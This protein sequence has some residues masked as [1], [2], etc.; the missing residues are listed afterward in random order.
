M[1]P[2]NSEYKWKAQWITAKEKADT[3]N[4]WTAFRKEIE[5]KGLPETPVMA[6][7][8]VDSKYWLWINGRQVVYEGQLK[9]GPTPVDTYYDVVDISEYLQEGKNTI[10]ALVWFFG[11]DGFSHNNSG[12]SGLVFDIQSDNLEIISDST[13][14]AWTHPSFET[15]G[16]PHP[17]YR[18][19][20]SNIAFNALK[21]DLSF[22]QIKFNDTQL[23]YAKALGTPPIAP[24]NRLIKR[25]IPQWRDFGLKAFE[26]DLPFPFT[27]TG[28]TI[29]CK[30]PYNAQIHPY[31]EIEAGEGLTID[32]RTDH[33]KGG[34]PPNVRAEYK[35]KNGMQQYENFGWMN[36]HIVKYYIP[37][38][39]KV[40]DLRYR[41]TGYKASFSGSFEC[42]NEFYNRL[43]DKS[44]RTLYVTM[45][46]NYMDCPDRE[47]AQWWGDEVLESGESFYALGPDSHALTK[48]GMLELI[49]W[50]R[51]DSTIFSPVPAGNWDQ[52]LPGQML[53]SI[54]YYG[55]WNYY[56]HTGDLETI[57]EVYEGVKKYLK[58]WSLKPDGTLKLRKGG[59]QWGDWGEHKDMAIIMNTQYYLALK[60]YAKMSEALGKDDEVVK[61]RALMDTF[62]TA[63]NKVFWKGNHFRSDGYEGRTDDRSQGLAV[64]A[65]LADKDKYQAIFQVL[66]SEKHASPYME[67]YIIEALFQMGYA[68]YGLERLKE[69]FSKMVNHPEIT[70][71]WEG[72]GIGA[73]GYGGGTVNH[74]WSG[75]GL[76]ILSQYVAGIFPT[77][78]G[79]HTFQ[80]KPQPGF[81]KH[82]KVVV[83][84]VKGDIKMELQTEGQYQMMVEVPEGTRASLYIPGRFDTVKMNGKKADFNKKAHY[85]VIDVASGMYT[86]NAD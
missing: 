38:G 46:D 78:P 37:K 11:K 84:S 63:F 5:L 80:V 50:Q 23:P 85:K 41:E 73:E 39:I 25:P 55:F 15:T 82:I 72:W 79:Y 9:R 32:I 54:G 59:W 76:T 57:K 10:A 64:V 43:W 22:V 16:P 71:L 6:N 51:A 17:N 36:G 49:N 81:L 3:L 61:T 53:A 2:V 14:K 27:A 45:R 40:L 77:S 34:G 42:G 26:N 62:K 33:Y 1:A 20:E 74:A 19:P 8:A 75:G 35:T 48:K 58:I 70:T 24:W 65:G 69:R 83:P 47:R 52:E 66:K 30:L 28:D 21:G 7:I 86:I 12:Q 56:W 29:E 60:G 13:W 67:K 4:V 18:L 44:L 68:K 31:L